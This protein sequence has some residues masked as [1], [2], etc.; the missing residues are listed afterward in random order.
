MTP[1]YNYLECGGAFEEKQL[2]PDTVRACI[3]ALTALLPAPDLVAEEPS[4]DVVQG[5][6]Q[7]AIEQERYPVSRSMAA[8]FIAAMRLYKNG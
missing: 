3:D 1:T 7:S 6:M 4:L 5:V 8:A 2:D